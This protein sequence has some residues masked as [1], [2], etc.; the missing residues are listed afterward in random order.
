MLGWILDASEEVGAG[1]KKRNKRPQCWKER[2]KKEER[3]ER[4]E[5]KEEKKE[6]KKERRRKER[7]KRKQTNKN[8]YANL[9]QR[10]LFI[11]ELV[12]V[13]CGHSCC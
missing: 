3:K 7:K 10:P 6:R 13:H 12:T 9:K 8:V 1:T 11:A 2:K 5:K 4:K